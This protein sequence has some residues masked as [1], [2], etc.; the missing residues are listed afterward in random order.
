MPKN[1][2]MKIGS[3]W[4]STKEDGTVYYSGNIDVPF[5]IT[6]NNNN[7]IL[8]F[9]NRSDHEKSPAMDILIA[10][11]QPPRT[12]TQNQDDSDVPF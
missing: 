12:Q 10:E 11:A 1:N 4:K 7:R 6:L 2:I 5:S 3:V 8:I 9:K